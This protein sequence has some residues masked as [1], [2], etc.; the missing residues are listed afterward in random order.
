M[1]PATTATAEK[2]L[3]IVR[4]GESLWNR[5]NRFTGWTD[6][7]LTERGRIE[8]IEAARLLKQHGYR[9]DFACTSLL[10]RAV[11]SLW[12]LLD[13]LG[14]SWLPEEKSWRLN[15]RHYGALEGLNKAVTAE[16][17]GH[18]QVM[19]WRRGEHVLLVSHSNV[20]RALVKHLDGLEEDALTALYVPTGVPIV[21]EFDDEIAPRQRYFL[22]D[23][24]DIANRIAE[25]I[26]S[27]SKK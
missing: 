16:R 12:L 22:G 20:I 25:V 27:G 5:E 10:V 19:A 2:R 15:E 24:Q 21:Y 3:V 9:F 26:R 6:V 23:E 7:K 4:H 13:E 1:T 8:A 11:H 18:E 17:Y 14:Q